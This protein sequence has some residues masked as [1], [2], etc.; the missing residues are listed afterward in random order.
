MDEQALILE[1][2]KLRAPD[3]P[4]LNFGE[5]QMRDTLLT[6]FG[7]NRG[8]LVGHLYLGSKLAGAREPVGQTAL[9]RM[10]DTGKTS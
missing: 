1:Y 5:M 9:P 3:E 7:M 8:R 10:W 6:M 2:E 4:C